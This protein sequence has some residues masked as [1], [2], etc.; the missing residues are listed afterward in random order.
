[1]EKNKFKDKYQKLEEIVTELSEQEQDIDKSIELFKEGI[2]LYKECQKDL[3]SAQE[4]VVKI[5][6]ENGEEIE[7]E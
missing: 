2:K 5:L 3:S 1:M 4:E 6:A 7:Y